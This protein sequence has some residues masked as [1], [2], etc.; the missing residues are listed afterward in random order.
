MTKVGEF[1]VNK[2]IDIKA[3]IDGQKGMTV[4]AWYLLIVSAFVML[5]DGY[6]MT[7]FSLTVSSMAADWGMEKSDFGWI[8]SVANIGLIFGSFIFG[9]IADKFG[10]KT[11]LIIA[12][13]VFAVTSLATAF[14]NNMYL[15]CV[16]RLACSLGIGGVAPNIVALNN[17]FAP[18]HAK[19]KRV[20]TLFVGMN[21]GSA[22]TGIIA[23]WLMPN[24]GWH[25]IYFVGALLPAAAALLVQFGIPESISWQ[26]ARSQVTGKDYSATIAKTLRKLRTDLEIPADATFEYSAKAEIQ[27]GKTTDLFRGKMKY[28]TPLLWANFI[29]CLFVAYFF[30]SWMPTILVEKG[31]TAS[32][33]SYMTSVMMFGS[34]AGSATIGFI[35]DKVGLRK[36]C[37]APLFVMAIAIIFGGLPPQ[38]GITMFVIILLG[39]GQSS[40]Y[41]IN[42][43]MTPLFYPVN[44]RGTA[45]G[46]NLG[47]G[48]IGSLLAPVVGGYMLATN[49]PI[50]TMFTI[51]VMPEVLS[52]IIV[53]AMT[54]IYVKQFKGKD[55]IEAQMGTASKKEEEPAQA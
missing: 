18:E 39:F 9:W 22:F 41:D 6:D 33:A 50:Q 48:R 11:S 23:G 38:M 21:C 53:F 1:R 8:M 51:V 27:K 4:F 31:F 28:I 44:L 19:I 10:R 15:M 26:M 49:M 46:M 42:P 43:S 40:S 34:M 36:A 32:E 25:S 55:I 17:D 30:K 13:W 47:I 20:T 16:I 5:V 12:L 29:I 37:I 24:F 3:A 7:S 14:V 54:T 2:V 52:A 35:L 45:S